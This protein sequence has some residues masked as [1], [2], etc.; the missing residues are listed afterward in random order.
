M[1]GKIQSIKNKEGTRCGEC[2]GIVSEENYKDFVNGQQNKI[3]QCQE[4]L[5]T[6]SSQ[7][8]MGKKKKKQVE[9]E[10]T[11]I[12][13]AIAAAKQQRENLVVKI[14]SARNKISELDKIQKPQDK[15]TNQAILENQLTLLKEQ[16]Y[17]K[18][19]E[20]DGPSPFVDILLKTEQEIEEK[21]KES[22]S[23]KN[24]L[25]EA[26]DD[27]PYYDFWVKGFGDKGIRKFVID[28]IIPA[29]NDRI[30]YWLQFLIDNKIK[31]KFDNNLEETIS[32]NPPDGDPFVYAQ[33]SRGEQ[34][35]L[36]LAVSQSFA[37]IM[38]LNSG[39]F[40][41]VV[42]LDEVTTN[43]DPMG[44]VGIYATINELAKDRIV[45]VTTHNQDL[46]Q[47]LEGCVTL[48]LEKRGGF[49]KIS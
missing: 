19:A 18:Q 14:N 16:I 30:S 21:E 29:L 5:S 25:I 43:V 15:N 12:Q 10:I 6:E 23:K 48:S 46:L 8:E 3:S 34:R 2:F 47:M 1:E 20:I 22:I 42:F 17:A 37:H 41:S 4:S 13:E 24:E 38:M 11:K 26:E 9:S 32:R 27:L 36:N 31:L 49:T 45:F 35:R 33:M 40:P 39:I 28:G 7:L 44:V